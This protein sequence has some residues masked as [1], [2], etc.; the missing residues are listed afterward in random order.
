MTKGGGGR[1]AG[2]AQ[3]TYARR[4][5][6]HRIQVLCDHD[7]RRI[8]YLRRTRTYKEAAWMWRS[9]RASDPNFIFDH[10]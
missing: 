3:Q 2:W 10:N 6:A 4:G 7:P 9:F 1:L 8:D 5:W